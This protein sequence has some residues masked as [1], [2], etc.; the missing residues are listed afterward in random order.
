MGGDAQPPRVWAVRLS[1]LGHAGDLH[2]AVM[3]ITAGEV[4]PRWHT[5]SVLRFRENGE[6]KFFHYFSDRIGSVS[7]L[8]CRG[9]IIIYL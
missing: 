8:K 4:L 1:L 5:L 3:I 2:N 9:I 7:D 6:E